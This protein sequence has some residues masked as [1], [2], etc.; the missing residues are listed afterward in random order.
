MITYQLD[1]NLHDRSFASDCEKT[2]L[3]NVWLFP[4][5][6]RHAPDETILPIFMRGDH[7][8]VTMD[9]LIASAHPFAIPDKNPGIVIVGFALGHFKTVTTKDVRMILS[10]FKRSFPEWSQTSIAGSILEL[11]PETIEVS[12][13]DNHR[14]HRDAD[15]KFDDTEWISVLK[16]VLAKNAKRS[17]RLLE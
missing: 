8:L 3:A 15:L 16:L 13:I 7:P 4:K 1:Q 2:K 17:Q 12:H 6:L 9:R 10:Q 14:I 5:K 11:T